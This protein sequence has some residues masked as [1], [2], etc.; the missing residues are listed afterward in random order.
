M[1]TY[2]YSIQHARSCA[3]SVQHQRKKTKMPDKDLL[4][5]FLLGIVVGIG[6]GS[7]S[8]NWYYHVQLVDKGH[9]EHNQRTGQWQWKNNDPNLGQE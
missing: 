2:H 7:A 8:V 5:I 9:A 1:V 4:I 3:T 6:I